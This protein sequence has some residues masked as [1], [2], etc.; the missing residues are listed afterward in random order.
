M[1][2]KEPERFAA[3]LHAGDWK[4]AKLYREIETFREPIEGEDALYKLTGD[5][6]D[7][8]RGLSAAPH[9]V[10]VSA[11]FKDRGAVMLRIY[12][13]QGAAVSAQI[14][15]PAAVTIAQLCDLL[16]RPTQDSRTVTLNGN[17]L[18]LDLGPWEIVTIRLD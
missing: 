13:N 18:E 7:T 4:T 5:A 14:N 6:P 17:R 1:L 2:P 9:N 15:L 11:F 10:M 16:G 12:E 8:Q 3:V